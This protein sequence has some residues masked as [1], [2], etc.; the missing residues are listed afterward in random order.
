VY[1]SPIS[2]T[3]EF[4]TILSSMNVSSSYFVH[5]CIVLLFYQQAYRPPILS[6][7]LSSYYFIHH[8]IALLYYPLGYR[9]TKNTNS[10]SCISYPSISVSS[11]Y[12]VPLAYCPTV[13]IS[14]SVLF[15]YFVHQRIPYYFLLYERIV[16]LFCPPVYHPPISSAL[17]CLDPAHCPRDFVCDAVGVYALSPLNDIVLIFHPH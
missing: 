13:L 9:P 15:S 10:R 17:A 3:S 2:S 6:T 1:C 8:H 14:I 7:S 16:L 4:P 11:S 5:P 12:F